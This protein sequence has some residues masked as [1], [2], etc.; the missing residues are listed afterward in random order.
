MSRTIEYRLS[1]WSL[2][3]VLSIGPSI[4]T[5]QSCDSDN[6]EVLVSEHYR[7]PL[8]FG[9]LWGPGGYRSDSIDFTPTLLGEARIVLGG[10][11]PD[12]YLQVISERLQ[13][14]VFVPGPIPPDSSVPDSTLCNYFDRFWRITETQIQQHQNDLADGNLD[15]PIPE[16][17]EWPGRGNPLL[18]SL[19]LD[20]PLAPFLDLN[21]NN[22]YEPQLGEYPSLPRQPANLPVL[23][24]TEMVW[25]M[26]SNANDMHS[27][28]RVNFGCTAYQLDGSDDEVLDRTS[29]YLIEV[30]NRS[31]QNLDSTYLALE[32]TPQLGC[33]SDDYMGFSEYSNLYF[34]NADETDG[35]SEN[36]TCD[37]NPPPFCETPPVV[38]LQFIRGLQRFVFLPGTTLIAD[39]LG[40]GV[41]YLTYS[42]DYGGDTPPGTTHPAN[43][44][45]MYNYLSGSWRDSSPLTFGEDGYQ[46]SEPTNRVFPG[47]PAHPGS[48]S[49]GNAGEQ[50]G[51]FRAYMS[52]YTNYF[53]IGESNYLLF[54]VTE[55][56]DVGATPDF[57]PLNYLMDQNVSRTHDRW[58]LVESDQLTHLMEP[59]VIYPNPTTREFT[60]TI[61][62]VS[63]QRIEIYSTQGQQIHNSSTTTI[64]LP[65][66]LPA[67]LYLVR[68]IDELGK[69]HTGRV[70]LQ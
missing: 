46:Q 54:G 63:I 28:L 67:G 64:R 44:W 57:I 55:F 30:N 14:D 37:V 36:C 59:V 42:R 50:P 26:F 62:H 7:A 52:S 48:W 41:E 61:D 25:W 12:G 69:S 8:Q 23:A 60:V 32:I 13:P 65:E 6:S 9:S 2:F 24:P 34:Y 53:P 58:N 1:W 56:P 15:D 10:F 5:A 38:G 20:M 39:T 45:E 43:Y 31:V 3:L 33:P 51:H 21:G 29:F 35:I 19:P 16:I 4:L 68:A 47:N 40:S 70:L 66:S 11:F 27:E 17:M 22:V 49:M 18:P